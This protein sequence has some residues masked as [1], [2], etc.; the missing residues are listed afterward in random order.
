MIEI[1]LLLDYDEGPIWPNKYNPLT[2]EK[3]SGI[4]MIDEDPIIDKISKKMS[5]M[6]DEYYQFNTNDSSCDFNEDKF[7]NEK[8]VMLELLQKLIDRLN[9]INDGSYIVIDE[10]SKMYE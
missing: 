9:E 5:E 1:R 7:M 6:Y 10:I 8:N 4:K 2:F 3:S